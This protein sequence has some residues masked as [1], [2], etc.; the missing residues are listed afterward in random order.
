MKDVIGVCSRCNKKSKTLFCEHCKMW[1]IVTPEGLKMLKKRKQI[2]KMDDR[3]KAE[4][5][6]A[7]YLKDKMDNEDDAKVIVSE[8]MKEYDQNYLDSIC[9]KPK[10]TEKEAL[11]FC[12]YILA[13]TPSNGASMRKLF[14]KLSERV[15][16]C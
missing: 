1:S 3:E 6:W 12:S 13:H 11:N 5:T 10:Y 7:E 15:M 2:L 14:D 8:T 16:G 9:A 4:K